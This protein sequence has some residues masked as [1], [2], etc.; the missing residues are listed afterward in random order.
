MTRNIQTTDLRRKR[1]SE[2]SESLR[3]D[4]P[5][6]FTKLN[7]WMVQSRSRW[8]AK[9]YNTEPLGAL[10]TTVKNVRE[11]EIKYASSSLF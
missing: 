10:T 7:V 1:I 11:W 6:T 4:G 9:A 5:S 8:D 3:N 2:I